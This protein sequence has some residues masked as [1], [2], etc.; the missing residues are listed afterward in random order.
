MVQLPVWLNTADW[1][2]QNTLSDCTKHARQRQPPKCGA[3]VMTIS[4]KNS[5]K[6]NN[7]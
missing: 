4:P 6:L 7:C 3:N 2:A 1:L 5:F